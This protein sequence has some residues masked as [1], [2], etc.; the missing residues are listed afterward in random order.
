VK[1]ISTIF[2]SSER[3]SVLADEI[4][5]TTLSGFVLVSQIFKGIDVT[6]RINI[7]APVR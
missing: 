7:A 2:H 1:I 4:D 3:L 6:M 5:I